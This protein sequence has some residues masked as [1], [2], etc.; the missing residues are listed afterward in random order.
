MASF[1]IENGRR[2]RKFR[3]ELLFFLF[4]PVLILSRN[5]PNVVKCSVHGCPNTN[6]THHLHKFPQNDVNRC[7]KW[8]RLSGNPKLLNVPLKDMHKKKICK[9]HFSRRM[10]WNNTL[11]TLNRDAEPD[12]L[13]NVTPLTT[14]QLMA[15]SEILGKSFQ[16]TFL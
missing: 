15:A 6:K 3:L 13:R 1:A 5:M 9:D 12:I 14:D 7:L 8:V 2:E 11:K 10:F 4:N 16:V